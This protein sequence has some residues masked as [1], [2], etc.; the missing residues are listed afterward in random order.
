MLI[1]ERQKCEECEKE[2]EW[3]YHVPQKW[4]TPFEAVVLPTGKAG[5]RKVVESVEKNGHSDH[6]TS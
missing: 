2:F 6:Y 4:N 5:V 1:E 3:F